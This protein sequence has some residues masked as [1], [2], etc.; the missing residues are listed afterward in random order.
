MPPSLIQP[1]DHLLRPGARD[2]HGMGRL[3]HDGDRIGRAGQR[4]LVVIGLAIGRI[5]RREGVAN[6]AA[7]R[8]SVARLG[9]GL[10]EV[11]DV[12]QAAGLQR[13]DRDQG[14]TEV[15]APMRMDRPP[16]RPS[17]AVEPL[18]FRYAVACV[19]PTSA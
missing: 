12:G 3:R 13:G 1:G 4:E 16:A 15:M 18:L 11:C 6:V 9:P 19:E 10:A 5:G 8:I 7:G 2:R 17:V 14:A